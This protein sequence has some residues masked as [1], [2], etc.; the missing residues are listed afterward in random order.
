MNERQPTF[1]LVWSPTGDKPPTFRHET[2]QAA[3]LEAERLA[4]D[5]RGRLFVVLEAKSARRVDDMVR[6]TFEDCAWT[7]E[8]YDA[9]FHEA[10]LRAQGLTP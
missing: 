9:L 2:E 3:T 6:T 5:H 10:Q 8:G 1:W 4:R 7:P